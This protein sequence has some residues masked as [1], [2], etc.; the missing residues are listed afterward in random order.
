[1][2]HLQYRSKRIIVGKEGPS[3]VI[4]K[5]PAFSVDISALNGAAPSLKV[6]PRQATPPRATKYCRMTNQSRARSV[7]FT[8]PR[9]RFR[10]VDGYFSDGAASAPR[11][12]GRARHYPQAGTNQVRSFCSCMLSTARVVERFIDELAEC[13]PLLV[14][15]GGPSTQSAS[16]KADSRRLPP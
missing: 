12:A 15:V 5:V 11:R 4:G 1:M 16:K 8:P 9:A 6:E 7:C 13:S 14:S 10:P 3:P 2:V